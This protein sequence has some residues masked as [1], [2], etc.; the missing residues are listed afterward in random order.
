MNSD[1]SSQPLSHLW[2]SPF[3]LFFLIS[4]V[5]NFSIIRLENKTIKMKY[6]NKNSFITKNS[7]YF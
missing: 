1:H 7:L 2:K 5:C 4:E 6:K 3:F